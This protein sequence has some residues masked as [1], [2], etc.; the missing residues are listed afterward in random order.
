MTG[1]RR[2]CSAQTAD[3]DQRTLLIGSQF[4]QPP[5]ELHRMDLSLALTPIVS[6]IAGILIFVFPRL[7]AKIVAIYLIA[8]GVI[9]LAG[10]G[11]FHF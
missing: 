2:C 9:G 11:N 3:P 8:V 4:P 10:A 7:L 6:L 1:H 5:K